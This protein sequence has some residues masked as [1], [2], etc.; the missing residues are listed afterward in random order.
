MCRTSVLVVD[1]CVKVGLLGVVMFRSLGF[2]SKCV[3]LSAI[4]F[5]FCW[6]WRMRWLRTSASMTNARDDMSW[7]SWFQLLLR[8]NMI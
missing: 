2:D 5:M 7:T 3:L 6:G 8:H 1:S 4:Y